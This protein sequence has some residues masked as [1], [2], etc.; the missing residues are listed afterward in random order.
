MLKKR[1]GKEFPFFLSCKVSL[2]FWKTKTKNKLICWRPLPRNILL[3]STQVFF[4]KCNFVFYFLFRSLAERLSEE[5][6]FEIRYTHTTLEFWKRHTQ[7]N[8][9]FWFCF[10][11]DVMLLLIFW[12]NSNRALLQFFYCVFFFQNY[13]V[14]RDLQKWLFVT[15]PH[16]WPPFWK[17]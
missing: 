13:F 17:R 15:Q 9:L 8:N 10:I 11:R 14:W 6:L 2:P 5:S 7:R 12:N 16:C 4:F 1:G 3:W